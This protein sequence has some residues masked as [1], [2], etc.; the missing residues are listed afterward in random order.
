MTSK[1]FVRT[2]R[3]S[4]RALVLKPSM[5]MQLLDFMTDSYCSSSLEELN[6]TGIL[7]V[8]PTTA[9]LAYRGTNPGE[10]GKHATVEG[11]PIIF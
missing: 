1:A 9:T 8:N 11:A 3:P 10:A 6:R 4:F 7:L 2:T 5:L